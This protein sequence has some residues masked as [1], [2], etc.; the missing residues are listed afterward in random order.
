MVKSMTTSN[1]KKQ[2]E[3]S[4]REAAF[5]DRRFWTVPVKPGEP[6]VLGGKHLP[7]G[8]LVMHN[9]GPGAIHVDT[10][11]SGVEAILAAGATDM[12]AIRGQVGLAVIDMKPALF[13]LE[14]LLAPK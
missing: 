5:V 2:P 6:K 9:R 1:R 11:Y 14:F 10:G 3:T 13:E 8:V 12:M 7:A 4:D